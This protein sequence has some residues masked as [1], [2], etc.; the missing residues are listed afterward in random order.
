MIERAAIAIAK[1][2][3]IDT[4]RVAL[5]RDGYT[6]HARAAILAALDLS[7]AEIAAI[8]KRVQVDGSHVREGCVYDV[9]AA[10]RDM[11]QGVHD[12]RE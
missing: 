1:V 5:G 10:L 8:A 3:G 4:K 7:D 11:A 12:A 6:T 2:D 9:R